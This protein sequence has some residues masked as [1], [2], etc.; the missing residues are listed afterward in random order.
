M[1]KRWI[2]N[3][4]HL[5]DG[6]ARELEMLN[7]LRAKVIKAKWTKGEA[8]AGYWEALRGGD[9]VLDDEEW[10]GRLTAR[11][12]HS[13]IA[14]TRGLRVAGDKDAKEIRRLA[15]KLPL[16]LAKDQRGRKWKW[17][18][19]RKNQSNRVDARALSQL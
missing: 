15:R 19:R 8:S 18:L 9:R 5:K 14:T 4:A 11:E 10:Q 7:M 12:I 13:H 16:R 2:A 1:R 6:N 3:E 17:P